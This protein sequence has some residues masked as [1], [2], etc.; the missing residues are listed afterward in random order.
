MGRPLITLVLAVWALAV[1]AE[2]RTQDVH[3][4][5]ED[6]AFTGYLAYDNALDGNAPA[7]SWYTSGGTFPTM[8]SAVPVC[9][10]NWVM[11]P[12]PWTCTVA[13]SIPTI[14]IKRGMEVLRYDADA[15][16][17]SWQ[18]MQQFFEE[19]FAD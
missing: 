11:W 19:I 7:Y 9:S 13:A 15:D 16:R 5:I 17:R 2:V 6:E 4:Q 8:K 14:R 1:Q 12:S 18:V 3:Y 10:P